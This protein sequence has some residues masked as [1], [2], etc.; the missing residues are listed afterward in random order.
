MTNPFTQRRP[1]RK[2]ADLHRIDPAAPVPGPEPPRGQPL[3]PVPGGG[4]MEAG[5]PQPMPQST[6]EPAAQPVVRTTPREERRGPRPIGGSSSEAPGISYLIEVVRDL[7]RETQRYRAALDHQS[8]GVGLYDLRGGGPRFTSVNQALAQMTGYAVDELQGR[9][10]SLFLNHEDDLERLL[11]LDEVIQSGRIETFTLKCRRKDGVVLPVEA[12]VVPAVDDY[13]ERHSLVLLLRDVSARLELKAHQASQN[14]K[15]N[16]SPDEDFRFT[17]NLIHELRT[18]LNA[19]IGFADVLHSEVFG[20]LPH[21]KYREYAVDILESGQHLLELV[22][23]ILDLSKADA[24][25]LELSEGPVDVVSAVQ[26]SLKMIEQT[27]EAARVEV[28]VAIADDLPRL[29]ADERRVRQILI[30]LL[31]NAVKFTPPGG[32][33]LLTADRE[34]DGGLFV[35]VLDTGIGMSPE[36]LTVAVAPFG[37]VAAP[38]STADQGTG[39]GLPLTQKL[40]EAHGGSLEIL[41]SCGQGTIMVGRFPPERVLS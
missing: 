16:R 1:E 5:P 30:N 33:V 36:D 13:G 26:S 41:S 39:L 29:S 19:I 14:A 32:E 31:A 18:P 23:E 10:H 8:E 12:T 25:R 3:R 40:L 11:R 28:S 2:G 4:R 6:P 35:S 15:R 21:D 27:A 24:G 7:K 9:D 37:Q 38:D 17:A 22:N 34:T 20:A